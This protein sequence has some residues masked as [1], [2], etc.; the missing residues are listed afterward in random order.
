MFE[1]GVNNAYY[2]DTQTVWDAFTS[3]FGPVRGLAQSL[4]PGRLEAFRRDLD[5]FHASFATEAGLHLKREY[6]IT[7]GR[8][9]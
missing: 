5:S 3:G 8:R 1:Q 7:I 6:L 9:R 4:D 2:P